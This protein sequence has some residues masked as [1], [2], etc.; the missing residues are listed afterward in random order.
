MT[1]VDLV[2]Y[3]CSKTGQIET[4]DQAACRA[5][6]SKRYELI[7]QSYLWKDALIGLDVT[8][9]PDDENN[10]E[11]IVL[12]PEIIDRVVAVRTA[13]Q[14]VRIRGLEEYYRVD[15][16]EFINTGLP[17][18][19]V[20][21][22]PIWFVWRGTVGLQLIAENQEDTGNCKITWRD[23]NGTSYTQ[24]ISA[25]AFLNSTTIEV[26][27][28]FKPVTLGAMSL[29]PQT[30][31]DDAGGTLT[32]T[33]TRSPSYQ[34]IRL[35]AIPR[36]E[37]IVSI[38]GKKKFTPLDF[39]QEEPLI[40]NLD[41]CL[42]AFAC[43]DMLKRARQYAK[44]NEELQQGAILLSELAKLEV[45]QAANNVKF[46]PDGGFSEGALFGPNSLGWY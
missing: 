10:A 32:T 1:L 30:S 27:S 21:L 42:I 3:V 34:R 9:D 40:K 16:N 5:F 35:F 17:Y 20:I 6:L 13:D 38:L 46:M 22:S 37:T 41:N 29:N 2:S 43:S 24:L 8:V 11:G 44:A 31:G 39:D 12:L 45:L 15:A 7:Y 36:E 28:F 33:E 23:V 4:E 19:F 18:S 25:G 14:S 26:E